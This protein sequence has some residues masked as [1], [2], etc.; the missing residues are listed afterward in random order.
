MSSTPHVQ[1]DDLERLAA[2]I[3]GACWRQVSRAARDRDAAADLARVAGVGAGDTTF[4][5]DLEPEALTAAWA[6]DLACRG[7]LSILTE[8]AGWR[9]LGPRARTWGQLPDFDHGGPRFVVDPVDGTRNLMFDLRSAW[10]AIAM[11]PP[12][13]SMPTLS[14]VNAAV[15]QELPASRAARAQRFVANSPATC[16]IADFQL[17]PE[18][19]GPELSRSPQIADDSAQ[20]DQGF[21]PFFHFHVEGRAPIAAIERRF[22]ARLAEHEGA[23]L[24]TI[25]DD[26]YISNAGQLMLLAQGKYRMIADLR[27]YGDSNTICSKP[28]DVAAAVFCARAAGAIVEV[29]DQTPLDATTPVA[30]TAYANAATAARLGP[31]LR[32]ALHNKDN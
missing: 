1:I 31:H 11:C 7:P 26:Q 27:A 23:D 24:D 6:E 3:A 19:L 25:F 21:F 15:V 14:E 18:G 32:S 12:G 5:I 28:Y 13:Q 16:L 29:P 9:H 8:D 30:F 10:A 2:Q 20:V 17:T 22:L 4:G